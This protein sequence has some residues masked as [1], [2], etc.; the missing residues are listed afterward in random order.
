M[1]ENVICLVQLCQVIDEGDLASDRIERSC[2]ETSRSC[3]REKPS[4]STLRGG[5]DKRPARHGQDHVASQSA[6][7]NEAAQCFRLEGLGC[8]DLI[9][10]LIIIALHL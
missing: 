7:N 10:I 9:I 5:L 6:A 2:A 1:L 8:T 3:L 4:G